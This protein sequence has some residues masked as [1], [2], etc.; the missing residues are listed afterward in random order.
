MKVKEPVRIFG[1]H[2]FPTL[3]LDRL[4][5]LLEILNTPKS[6]QEHLDYDLALDGYIN[7][8]KRLKVDKIK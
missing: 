4:V 6:V 2:L 7:L 8:T 1:S 5:G 3:I